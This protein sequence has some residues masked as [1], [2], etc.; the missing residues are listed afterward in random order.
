MGH[1]NP[2]VLQAC[3]VNKHVSVDLQN[4]FHKRPTKTNRLRLLRS[5]AAEHFLGA[6]CDLCSTDLH[7]KLREHPKYIECC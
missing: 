2:K 7:Q 4:L 1:K 3:Y 5:L 6:P